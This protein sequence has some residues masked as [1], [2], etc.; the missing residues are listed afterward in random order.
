MAVP[1]QTVPGVGQAQIDKAGELT[2]NATPAVKKMNNDKTKKATEATEASKW[3]MIKATLEQSILG[4]L[5]YQTDGSK[6]I[7]EDLR[8]ANG[9][10]AYK[11][12]QENLQHKLN[13]FKNAQ[14]LTG[15]SD[16]ASVGDGLCKSIQAYMDWREAS[17]C[18]N[19]IGG[20][21]QSLNV[22]VFNAART[23][24]PGAVIEGFWDLGSKIAK[25]FQSDSNHE[26]V[27]EEAVVEEEE[28]EIA[29]SSLSAMI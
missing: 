16:W 20:R 10:Q 7:L 14:G 17:G 29:R 19:S 25:E 28:P 1:N 3:E 5:F 21:F 27:K 22:G 6:K 26:A 2:E 15:S 11:L 9:E 23:S 4:R 12:A 8:N 18:P 24:V 13:A